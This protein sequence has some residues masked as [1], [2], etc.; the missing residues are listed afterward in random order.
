MATFDASSV[1][2]DVS[3]SYPPTLS[4]QNNLIT[5]QPIHKKELNSMQV[6]LINKNIYAFLKERGM[7]HV[8]DPNRIIPKKISVNKPYS[9]TR[10]ENDTIAT[11]YLDTIS[12]GE[13]IS[14]FS[15]DP[16]DTVYKAFTINDSATTKKAYYVYRLY[17][18]EF[19][20]DTLM[21]TEVVDTTLNYNFDCEDYDCAA[22]NAYLERAGRVLS[23]GCL[24]YTSPSPRD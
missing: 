24:L 2:S 22:E 10:I 6:N 16:V 9:F 21:Y 5:I 14:N 12:S 8:L 13:D 20:T 15:S 4:I 11:A 17:K 18:N 23:W 19:K 3:P 7:K 1:G